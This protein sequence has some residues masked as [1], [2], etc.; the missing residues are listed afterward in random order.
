M[1]QVTANSWTNDD[2]VYRYIT[3]SQWVN[4][5]EMSFEVH[6]S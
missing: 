6:D 1:K 4:E 3:R 2:P 5:K